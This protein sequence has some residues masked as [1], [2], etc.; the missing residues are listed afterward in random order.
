MLPTTISAHADTQT[1]SGVDARSRGRVPVAAAALADEAPSGA[2]QTGAGLGGQ[3]VCDEPRV[4]K[5]TGRAPRR[6]VQRRTRVARAVGAAAR[7][8]ERPAVVVAARDRAAD[9]CDAADARAVVTAH[10]HVVSDRNAE[11]VAD[12]GRMMAMMLSDEGVRFS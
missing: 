8:L 11:L 6:A 12:H 4:T 7:H 10:Q 3:R 5:R 9:D 2:P 1:R